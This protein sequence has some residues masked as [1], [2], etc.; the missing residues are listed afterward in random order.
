M[1]KKILV[2]DDGSEDGGPEEIQGRALSHVR[3]V[4]SNGQGI[5]AALNKVPSD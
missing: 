2:I 4:T 3:V 1:P 5:A